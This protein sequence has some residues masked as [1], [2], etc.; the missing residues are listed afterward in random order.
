MGET[1]SFRPAIDNVPSGKRECSEASEGVEP[2]SY[3]VGNGEHCD[4]DCHYFA[5][6]ES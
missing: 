6:Q 3:V 2:R 4:H 5:T 1:V